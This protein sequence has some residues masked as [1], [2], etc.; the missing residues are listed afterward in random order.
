M[1]PAKKYRNKAILIKDE[2]IIAFGNQDDVTDR[3]ALENFKENAGFLGNDASNEIDDKGY[4]TGL[5][6]RVPT[7]KVSMLGSSVIDGVES[8]GFEIEYEFN[9]DREARI[10][11]AL[12][13]P[14][15]SGHAYDTRS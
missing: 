1:N 8:L 10:D 11:I 7:L 2:E 5:S 14:R 3:Y 13:D 9:E 12:L 15:C 4:P 6:K